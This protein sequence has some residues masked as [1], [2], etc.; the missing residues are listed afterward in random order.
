MR[1]RGYIGTVLATVSRPSAAAPPM[2]TRVAMDE[3]LEREP[4]GWT[5]LAC[6][7]RT[8]YV[9]WEWLSAWCNAFAGGRDPVCH[10]ARDGDGALRGVALCL[11]RGRRLES[12]TNTHSGDWNVLGDS[13]E[14]RRELWRAIAGEGAR[15]LELSYL[16]A[17]A[18]GF[19]DSLD[20]LRDGGYRVVVEPALSSPY[21]ELPESYDELLAS[22]SAKLRKQVARTRRG[23]SAEGELAFEVV[24][25]GDDL[26]RLLDEF[27]AVEAS[28][29]KGR[30]GTAIA[31]DERVERLYRR[32]A[33]G[34][35]EQ[36]W[37][38]LCRLTLDGQLVAA[39]FG[40]VLGGC[41]F[42]LKTAFDE[43]FAR[44]SPGTLLQ[45]EVLRDLLDEGVRDYDFLGSPD[46]YKMRW[47]RLVRPR[48]TVRAYAGPSTLP[49]WTWRSRVRPAAKSLRDAGRRTLAGRAGRAR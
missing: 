9:T 17:H 15:R 28:G 32:F 33:H 26:D 16:P 11:Q 14:T 42:G 35:A 47:A 48:L 6:D 34:A 29:W 13:A 12:P 8:P 43:R 7:A 23:L 46:S 22:L 24:R 45:A 41:G 1:R 18:P 38:R 19:A 30:E 40:C 21:M 39:D 36:G 27:V 3:L 20:V 44:H 4:D 25:G 31:S 49:A 5:D 2:V 10:V 37:L